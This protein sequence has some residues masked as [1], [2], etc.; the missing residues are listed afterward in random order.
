MSDL[1]SALFSP[2]PLYRQTWGFDEW[3]LHGALCKV[4][5]MIQFSSFDSAELLNIFMFNYHLSGIICCR[6]MDDI[7]YHSPY[8]VIRA[9]SFDISPV[10]NQLQESDGVASQGK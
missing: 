8:T 9:F 1:L 3:K 10:A 4:R 7:C 2:L 6:C 5:I